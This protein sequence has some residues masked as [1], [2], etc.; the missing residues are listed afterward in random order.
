MGLKNKLLN[1][2]PLFYLLI[3]MS[4]FFAYMAWNTTHEDQWI[5]EGTT[6]GTVEQVIIPP[7]R[8]PRYPT[9]AKV[10]LQNG[11][12]VTISVG[13]GI[14]INKGESVK[15]SIYKKRTNDK[16]KYKLVW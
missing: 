16:L 5:S 6:T 2:K 4:L 15:L 11:E 8:T 12:Q 7:S 13:S 3:A 14:R 9:L 1:N 10:R